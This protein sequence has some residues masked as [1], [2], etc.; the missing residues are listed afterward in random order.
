MLML[1]IKSSTSHVCC[2]SLYAHVSKPME[3]LNHLNTNTQK[4]WIVTSSIYRKQ[5]KVF[6]TIILFHFRCFFNM[7]NVTNKQILLIK[8]I[9]SFYHL[10]PYLNWRLPK[11]TLLPHK[12]NIILTLVWGPCNAKKLKRKKQ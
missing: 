5:G 2:N 7:Q 12:R 3:N 8:A 10:K 6:F 9:I 4:W 1:S 11:F